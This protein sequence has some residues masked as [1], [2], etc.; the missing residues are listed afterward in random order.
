MKE[1]NIETMEDVM[2]NIKFREQVTNG[3]KETTLK[4]DHITDKDELLIEIITSEELFEDL[5]TYWKDLESRSNNKISMSFDWVY[6]W[7]Q[8]F[9]TNKQRS[10]YIITLWDGTKLVG[11]APFYKG[12][13]QFSGSTLEIRLQLI[14]SGGSRNEQIGYTKDNGFNNFLD[15]IVDNSYADVVAKR[16]EEILTP[17]FIGVDVVNFHQVSDTSFVMNHLYP[18]LEGQDRRMSL[19]QMNTSPYIDLVQQKIL[20]DYIKD[21]KS[22]GQ[23]KYYKSRQK[24]FDKEI[25]IEDVTSSW[26]SVEKA[27][28]KMIELHQNQRKQ[29]GSPVLFDDKR[30]TKFFRDVVENAYQNDCLWFKQAF[31]E[32]GIYASHVAI[33][34]GNCYYDYVSGRNEFWSRS[35]K[36]SVDVGL[37]VNLIEG[38]ISKGIHRIESLQPSENGEYDFISGSFK[39]WKLTIPFKT[40]KSNIFLFINRVKAFF[41]RYFV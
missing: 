38:A 21:S 27:M 35:K 40:Q 15:I 23:N 17:E 4:W 39:N 13:M 2:K 10:L 18:R 12:Y 20:K 32:D 9:G 25:V 8:H 28:N 1:V 36:Y 34:Y 3:E 26:K 7:W 14:G 6:S 5:A 31:D 29:W 19:K 37:L 33:K 30:F 24:K 41:H 16:M 22:N 11:L